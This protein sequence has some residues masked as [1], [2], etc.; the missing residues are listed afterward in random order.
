[1]T[2]SK[3]RENLYAVGASL[4]LSGVTLGMYI[5]Q[6]FSTG[7][8]VGSP[9]LMFLSFVFLTNWKRLISLKTNVIHT[10]LIWLIV[11]Q[12]VMI[13]YGVMSDEGN[14]TSQ[15]LTFH[16]YI[17]A[18]CLAY[19][20]HANFD[21]I[22]RIP[23]TLFY[24][25]L[26]AA[27]LGAYF[28][29]LGIVSGEDAYTLRNNDDNYVLEMFTVANGALLNWFSGL[30][31]NKK[32]IV[33]KILFV[34]ALALD[35][36][37][38]VTCT[39]RT[40]MVVM[41]AGTVLYLYKNGLLTRDVF[42]KQAKYLLLGVIAILYAYNSFPSFQ[43]GIDSLFTRL[44]DGVGVLVGAQGSQ[45]IEDS[46]QSRVELRELAYY[47]VTTQFNFFN[48]IF[49]YGYLTAWLD[50]P[51]IEAYLD[52]GIIGFV[53]YFY[54]AILVPIK[55]MLKRHISKVGL[56]AIMFSLYT[57]LSAFNSG[58]PYAYIKYTGA[59]MLLFLFY[60]KKKDGSII[61]ID[62]K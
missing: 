31:F 54:F 48:F 30:T 27:G 45:H 59:C 57:L 42:F 14:M 58:N 16:L 5:N 15:Y 4:S 53:A 29:S 32:N 11:F 1:M 28:C 39:K 60:T 49:G 23:R 17:I 9:L 3:L 24:L 36:Y 18:I 44:Y 43:E 34:V 62:K 13:F 55:S 40:P 2:V 6:L 52:M 8:G 41:I 47:Y 61:A 19:G 50:A 46:A 26:I 10:P 21:F 25:S 38:V 51:L 37:I 35:L 56:L 12:W 20:S 22:E 33:E 7:G